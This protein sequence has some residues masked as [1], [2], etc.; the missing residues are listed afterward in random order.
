MCFKKKKM[1]N[2][3]TKR[4]LHCASELSPTTPNYPRSLL[5]TGLTKRLSRTCFPTFFKEIQEFKSNRI[6]CQLVV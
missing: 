1:W 5:I 3:S 2:I 4:V 6:V